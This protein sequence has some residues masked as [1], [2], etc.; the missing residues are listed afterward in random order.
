MFKNLFRILIMVGIFGFMVY[1]VKAQYRQLWS[2]RRGIPKLL[3][4]VANTNDDP[5]KEV[6]DIYST[7]ENQYIR[8]ID[9]ATGTVEWKS[10]PFYNIRKPA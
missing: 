9:G 1:P 7:I 6:V 4:G 10:D 2:N 3:L 5:A 8:V